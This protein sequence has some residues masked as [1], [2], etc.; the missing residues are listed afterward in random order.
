MSDI[1]QQLSNLSKE[2]LQQL[3]GTIDQILNQRVQSEFE[4]LSADF[5][6]LRIVPYVLVTY[7]EYL[8]ISFI[9]EM[10]A[11]YSGEEYDI[12][13][14]DDLRNDNSVIVS[15]FFNTV[16]SQPGQYPRI[17]VQAHMS[18]TQPASIGNDAPQTQQINSLKNALM[19]VPMRITIMTPNYSEANNLANNVQMGIVE[20]HDILRRVFKLNSIS[21][22]RMTSGQKTREFQSI[23]AATVDFNV[24]KYVKWQNITRIKEYKN[25]ILRLVARMKDDK[26]SPII[27]AV[28]ASGGNVSPELQSYLRSIEK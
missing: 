24:T 20:N 7:M 4:G 10:F 21:F 18:D 22:P 16:D 19:T 11:N 27:M 1:S 26:D 17:V 12:R 6:D 14:S 28:L 23:F 13:C 9:E 2:S 5:P 8:F 15:Q 25:V 3:R